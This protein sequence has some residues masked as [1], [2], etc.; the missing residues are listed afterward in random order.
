MHI[1]NKYKSK[2]NVSL[3]MIVGV[4]INSILSILYITCALY[5]SAKFIFL[6]KMMVSQKLLNSDI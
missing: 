5:I 2:Q 6:L 3:L 1:Y 4:Q